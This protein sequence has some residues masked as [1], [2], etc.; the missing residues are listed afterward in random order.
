MPEHPL[1]REDEQLDDLQNGYFIIQG[2]KNF[3][4][5]MDAVLLADYAAAGPDDR[6]L[7]MCTGTG[8]VPILL[9]AR[10][11]GKEITGL[12]IQEKS[13][14]MAERSVRINHLQDRIRIIRGDI[15]EAASFFD[16]ASFDIVTCNPPYMIGGH[17]LKNPDP[18]MAAARHEIFCTFRDVA[19]QAAYLL[20]PHGYFYLIHRPFRLA[21]IMDT[22]R[23]FHLEPKKMRLVY[24][25]VDRE[26]NLVLIEARR[27]GR[28]RLE[29]EKPLI[30]YEKPGVYTDDIRAIYG[31]GR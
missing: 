9:A 28:P 7:D 27:D 4:Y 26:P 31:D 16:A 17:G 3:R 13:A 18:G 8:I 11:R 10:G 21:E 22:L 1:L 25:Y 6:I 29:V 5:G 30:V 24:P 12:E 2:D 20:A 14:D 15:R 19:M 23:E